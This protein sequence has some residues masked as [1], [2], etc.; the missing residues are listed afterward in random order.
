MEHDSLK[1]SDAESLAKE[2][3]LVDC[4]KMF[5]SVEEIP[6]REGINCEKCKVP[7]HH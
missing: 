4:L 3:T 6:V 7:T 5:E 1:D 2:A